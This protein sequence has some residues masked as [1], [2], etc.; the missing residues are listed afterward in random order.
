MKQDSSEPAAA[1]GRRQ[2]RLPSFLDGVIAAYPEVWRAYQQLGKAA[3]T[4]GPLDARAQRMV[5]LALA[6]GARSQG[7]VHSHAR[8]GL[9]ERGCGLL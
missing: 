8:R 5:K 9:R 6:V 4:A 2:E 1:G 3:A 7:A